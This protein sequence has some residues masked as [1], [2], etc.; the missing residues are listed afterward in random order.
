VHLLPAD[1]EHPVLRWMEGT[2]LRPVRARLDE[3][4]WAGFRADLGD[5]LAAAY[6]EDNGLVVFPFRRIFVVAR[7]PTGK[8]AS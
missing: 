3:A 4:A 7:T 5:R 1:R 6:P 2:A 8:E